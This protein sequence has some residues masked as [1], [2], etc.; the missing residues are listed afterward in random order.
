VCTLMEGAV[1]D[2]FPSF[3]VLETGRST[4]DFTVRGPVQGVTFAAR[5][6]L[7]DTEFAFLT[8]DFL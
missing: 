2:P 7:P 8:K 4:F 5:Y 1:S 3:A 6:F